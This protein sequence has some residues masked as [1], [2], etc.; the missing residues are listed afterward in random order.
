MRPTRGWRA[1]AA[2]AAGALIA[3]GPGAAAQGWPGQPPTSPEVEAALA[4]A[5]QGDTGDL[6]RLADAG[7]ADAQ[8]YVG[9][10]YLFGVGGVAKDGAKGC[11]Y[12]R[13][14]AATR[15]D[16]MHV[17]GECYEFGYAGEK[18]LEK[19]IA[20]F[21]KAGD[22]GFPKSRC[23]E[24]NVL[25]KL[26][27]DEARAFALCLEGARGGDPDAQTDVGNYYLLG[28]HVAKDSAAARAW[29]EMAVSANR[30]RN[31]AF[32]L[33]Q[34]YWLGDG[35]PKD[36]AK[37]VV[38]WKMAYEGG[39][40]DAAVLLGDEAF[41]RAFPDVTAGRPATAG[42]VRVDPSALGQSAEWYDKAL[43]AGPG[44]RRVDIEARLRLLR[45][46]QAKA[47]AA[48]P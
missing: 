44:D 40:N 17:V 39:R 30:Q 46:L 20:A 15:A 2:V 34:M 36:A 7:R 33:G 18:N 42:Q 14:A 12:E 9:P 24:G 11:A 13:K 8:Y 1:L 4:R 6:I 27:R 3:W 25:F 48:R 38:Y 5:R 35:I 29:Y 21:R 47:A 41:A 26:G 31:A 22:M 45:E 32:V 28:Q 37:A 23:A 19:A 43:A 16:A 10:F